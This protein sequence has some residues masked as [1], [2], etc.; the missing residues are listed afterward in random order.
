[1]MHRFR[2]PVS[3][4]TH[5]VSAFLALFGLLWLMI[6]TWHTP[7]KMLSLVI[8]GCCLIFQYIASSALHLING[9]ERTTL[10]L[11]RIDHAAIYLLIAG[12][13]TPIAYNVLQGH[14]RWGVLG[15]VWTV[16]LAG[17]VFK[18]LFL[19]GQ[20]RYAAISYLILGWL[21]IILIPQAVDLLPMNAALMI[22]AGGLVYTVGAVIFT[23]EKPNFHPQFG[24]HELWH[25][26]VMVG[27]SIHFAAIM[28][29][30]VKA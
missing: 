3:G 13:Y 11:R 19:P 27:S 20:S 8:Y 16:A 18:L 10:W 14:W 2:E 22:L 23:L 7:A 24:F 17:C 28:L 12:T 4:L 15:I 6:D 21:G 29:Y 30:I 25:L 1:M 26:F 5:L 9:S